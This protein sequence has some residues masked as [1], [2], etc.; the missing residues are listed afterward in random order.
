VDSDGLII[1]VSTRRPKECINEFLVIE[2]A[3]VSRI[4]ALK[5]VHFYE[6]LAELEVESSVEPLEFMRRISINNKLMELLSNV[7]GEKLYTFGY[8]L[9]KEGVLPYES[10]WLDIEII[11][12]FA[13]PRSA[14]YI[15]I[16]YRS[17]DREK[18]LEKSKN[19]EKMVTVLKSVD[20]MI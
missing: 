5:Q 9:T 12:S 1:G 6:L 4:E 13:R 14:F 3:I 11:P 10:E 2:K 19:I 15:S 18:V 20:N 8:R 7:L 17:R 16:V